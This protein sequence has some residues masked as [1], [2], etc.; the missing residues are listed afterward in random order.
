[1]MEAVYE[2]ADGHKKTQV[3]VIK[4]CD[5]EWSNAEVACCKSVLQH[6]LLLA[7]P[8]PEKLLT[9]YTDASASTGVPQ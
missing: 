6:A 2:R 9:V 4:L 1:M 7:H 5:V 8:D 3:R